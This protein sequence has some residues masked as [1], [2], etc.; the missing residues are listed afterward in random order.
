MILM[1]LALAYNT[2]EVNGQ[3][4]C[5]TARV[6]YQDR[7]LVLLLAGVEPRQR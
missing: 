3:S 4:W 2:T 6:I 1:F 5:S 7:S